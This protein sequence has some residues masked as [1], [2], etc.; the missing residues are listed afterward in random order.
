[1]LNRLRRRNIAIRAVRRQLLDD[2][3]LLDVPGNGGLRG[4]KAALLQLVQK[5]LLRL[6]VMLTDER[7]NLFLPF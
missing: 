5:L 3:K 7:K 2:A 1:M 4:L 6:N